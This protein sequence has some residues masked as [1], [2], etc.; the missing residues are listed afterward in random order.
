[1][2]NELDE[3]SSTFDNGM[4]AVYATGIPVIVSAIHAHV[5]KPRLHD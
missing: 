4:N 3:Q 5:I 1:M 2:R